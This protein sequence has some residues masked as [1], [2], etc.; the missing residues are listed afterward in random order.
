MHLLLVDSH[1]TL[2]AD[3]SASA[4]F[5]LMSHY[6]N[7]FDLNSAV[8]AGYHHIGAH[9]LM[10]IDIPSQ[11]LRFTLDIGFTLDRS[12]LTGLVMCLHL[13]VSKNLLAA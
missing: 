2:A 12:I 9:G 13:L 8:D 1:A 10:L 7:A 4:A 3:V 5:C 11:A 6:V